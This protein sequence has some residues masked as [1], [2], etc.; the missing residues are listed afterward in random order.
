[1]GLFPDWAFVDDSGGIYFT[2]DNSS[3]P[4][5]TISSWDA[6]R[7]PWRIYNDV[8]YTHQQEPRAETYLNQLQAFY[9]N[10]FDSGQQI[11]A[12]YYYVGSPAVYY[13]SPATSGIPLLCASLNPLISITLQTGMVQ[14]ALAYILKSAP[15]NPP[16]NNQFSGPDTF[17]DLNKTTGYFIAPGDILR[18]YINSWGMLGLITAYDNP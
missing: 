14:T 1:M 8:K 12:S 17:R 3:N 5:T 2:D 6:F 18:Y 9:Q 11:Y 13:T 10:Q 16:S 15:T 7:L 4:S